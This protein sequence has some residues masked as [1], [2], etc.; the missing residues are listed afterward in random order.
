MKNKALLI[1]TLLLFACQ[2]QGDKKEIAFKE[3]TVKNNYYQARAVLD[4]AIATAG[5]RAN[6][7]S[8][9]KISA[10][11]TGTVLS[12]FQ[13]PDM[14]NLHRSLKREGSFVINFENDEYYSKSATHWPNFT[15]DFNMLKTKDTVYNLNEESKS[16]TTSNPSP[17][18]D[19]WMRRI[20]PYLLK[21][22]KEN[23]RSLRYLGDGNDGSKR[24]KMVS[25]S[26]SDQLLTLYFDAE[27]Y[28]LHKLEFMDYAPD[29]G[30]SMNRL[31]FEEYIELDEIQ[32]AS[33]L[34]RYEEDILV[35]DY[36]FSNFKINEAVDKTK[37]ELPDYKEEETSQTPR[38]QLEV[39]KLSQTIYL[40]KNLLG[41]D[42]N[43]AF[44]DFGEY[45]VALETPLSDRASRQAI[46]EISKIFPDKPIKYAFIT[47]FHGDHSSGFKEYIREGA[48]IIAPKG[49]KKYFDII[50]KAKHSLAG[51]TSRDSLD[52]E[53][54]FVGKEGYELSGNDLTLKLVDIGPTS[55]VENILVAY[56]PEE[57][58][59]FQGDMFRVSEEDT[60]SEP[61][62]PEAMEFYNTLK[63]KGWEIDI[64]AGTHGP[65]GS[66]R[67]LERMI[68]TKVEFN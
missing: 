31:V 40:V 65:V 10:S 51:E 16:Y 2:S 54:I 25:A 7:D 23:G 1:L 32:V 68:K 67:D 8:L 28:Q 44:V 30:D 55:H 6:L 50:A 53:Y 59:L 64:L 66:F 21:K 4:S 27:T 35:L 29:F 56:I 33:R 3:L 36:Q 19:I 61:V 39:E 48:T 11:Y 17:S 34:R 20:T 15:S 57:K 47:H 62:R 63:E 14:D 22:S 5:G 12:I 58:F 37:L 60:P 26:V 9:S 49:T 45:L 43:T 46:E 24:Y 13:G 41:R 18:Q 52:P 38:P 42:Y